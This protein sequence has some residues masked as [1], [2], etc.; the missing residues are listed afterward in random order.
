MVSSIKGPPKNE[1]TQN[2]GVVDEDKWFF[3]ISRLMD[4]PLTFDSDFPIEEVK[5]MIREGEPLSAIVVVRGQRPVGLVMSLHMDKILS[6]QYGV[7][8]YYRKS[9]SKIMDA[10]PLIVGRNTPLETVAHMAMD[11]E[12]FRIYD[13]IIVTDNGQLQGTV[14]VQRILT[15]L[16]TLQQER[17]KDLSRINEELQAGIKERM[18]IEAELRSLNTE[19]ERSNQDLQDFTYTVSHDLQEPLRK[20]HAFGHFLEEDYSH[21]LPEDALDYLHRMQNAAVRMKRLIQHLLSISRVGTHGKELGPVRVDEVVANAV[22]TL[23]EIIEGS[24]CQ[25]QIEKDLPVVMADRV[26]LEQLFQNLIS[27][28]I[29]FTPKNSTPVISIRS[30]ITGE[31]A[32]FRVKDNGLGIEKKYLKKIFGIFQRL[33]RRE[34]YEGTGVGLALCEKIVQRH[35]GKIWAESRPGCGTTFFFILKAFKSTEEISH[36]KISGDCHHPHTLGRG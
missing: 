2:A 25:L 6:H 34:E 21:L 11:R 10:S 30:E 32:T 20:I 15:T 12:R 29:K 8:L 24:H 3:P 9:I 31:T 22:E 19:I 26:Q 27:N 1:A 14:S 35:G 23:S 16:A 17:A 4:T 18:R 28:A 5:G 13:H 33:H 36:G 7:S